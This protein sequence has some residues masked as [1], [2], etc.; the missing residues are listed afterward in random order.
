[1][2]GTLSAQKSNRDQVGLPDTFSIVQVDSSAVNH[3][4]PVILV[5]KAN[6]SPDSTQ[7]RFLHAGNDTLGYDSTTCFFE[8]DSELTEFF[9]RNIVYPYKLKSKN[10]EEYLY[11][12]LRINEDGNVD[13]SE[14]L[15]SEIPE[16]KEEVQRVIKLLPAL[17]PT[18]KAG[19][20]INTSIRLPISFRMLH[21]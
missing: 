15:G 20:K 21:L 14:V 16:M 5:G 11:V 13:S 8:K 7:V 9:V 10:A 6:Y 18:D 1:M 12:M 3:H 4:F 17:V 19:R 2:A